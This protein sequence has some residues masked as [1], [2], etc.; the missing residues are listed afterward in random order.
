MLCYPVRHTVAVGSR[1]P[2]HFG[3]REDQLE[4]RA[5]H[6]VSDIEKRRGGHDRL[7]QQH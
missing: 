2:G 1:F 7:L 5:R 4:K 3:A 6:F